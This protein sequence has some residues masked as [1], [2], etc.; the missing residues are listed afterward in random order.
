MTLRRVLIICFF[1]IPLLLFSFQTEK[2]QIQTVQTASLQTEILQTPGGVNLEFAFRA[3]QPG[4]IILVTLKE[5]PS[6]KRATIRFQGRDYHLEKKENG[7]AIFVFIGLDLGLK[8][9]RY[10]IKV[11]IERED[12]GK[13]F[14][15]KEIFVQP[16]KF[17]VKKLWV[18]GEFVTP[19]PEVQERIQRE[20]DLLQ[21]VYSIITPDWLGRGEF[22]LPFSGRAVPNFGERRIYNNVPRSLHAGVDV[23]A[24]L[25]TPIQASN[26]GKVVL[27]SDLYFSGKTVIIDHGLG[28]FTFYCHFS[29]LMVKRGDWVN[30]GDVI[31]KAGSTGRSTGP[32]LHWGVKVYDSRVDPFSLISL[33]L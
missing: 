14:S 8:P 1:L 31:G 12:G 19:P 22:I 20:S 18:K 29:R 27:A 32:H 15:Q 11:S 10:L 2:F 24:P 26:S 13:D 33:P 16:K 17:P 23:A 28:L 6:L 3:Y 30:K 5:N 25:G 7:G 9:D 21:A 4:E